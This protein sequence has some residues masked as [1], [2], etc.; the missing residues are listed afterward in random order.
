MISLY[1]FLAELVFFLIMTGLFEYHWRGHDFD[2]K[3]HVMIR[4]W[5][6]SISAICL[7]V[8]AGVVIGA[9]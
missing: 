7:L 6:Y 2:G 4:A 8:M 3:T 5:Y 9:L 1:I